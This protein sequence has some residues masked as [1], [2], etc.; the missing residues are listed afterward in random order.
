MLKQHR[1]WGPPA[2]KHNLIQIQPKFVL[3]L[4]LPFLSNHVTNR[5]NASEK[6]SQPWNP[7]WFLCPP[8]PPM[9]KYQLYLGKCF[10]IV[11]ALLSIVSN[12]MQNGFP[13]LLSKY[14]SDH[15]DTVRSW[16]SPVEYKLPSPQPFLWHA[17]SATFLG[18]Q[19]V[20]AGASCVRFVSFIA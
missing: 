15:C 18:H 14:F 8:C 3:H 4:L 1:W 9:V 17:S 12:S 19:V 13:N 2:H 20:G 7:H 5:T 16:V 6:P 11:L 10:S